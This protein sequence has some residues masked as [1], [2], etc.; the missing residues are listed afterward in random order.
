[1]TEPKQTEDKPTFEESVAKLKQ[2]QVGLQQVLAN[3][4]EKIALFEVE[5]QFQ[6]NFE[7]LKRDVETRA[8]NLEGEVKRL[9]QDLKS[10][11]ELLGYNT[12]K[13]NS[14]DS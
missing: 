4:R 10:I 8:D 12:E 13:N 1:M 14:P 5:P 2:I 6:E 9:R 11:K 7:N 3:L